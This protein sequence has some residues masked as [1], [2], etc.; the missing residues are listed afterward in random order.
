MLIGKVTGNIWATR[1]H[2]LL[3]GKKYMTV[4]ILD[5]MGGNTA[6]ALV[7]VDIIGAGIGETV[8]V[9][10]GSSAR[11]ALE[12]DSIPVDAAIVGIIDINEVNKAR[13]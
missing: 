11:R 7:A 12:N 1:K 8:L 5:E 2:A 4:E 9:T 10:T 6:S 13:G 3:E